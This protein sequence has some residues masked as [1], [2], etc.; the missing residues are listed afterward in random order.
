MHGVN[1][2]IWMNKV[3]ELIAEHKVNKL[4]ELFPQNLSLL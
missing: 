1:P 4:Y 2:Q 3:L